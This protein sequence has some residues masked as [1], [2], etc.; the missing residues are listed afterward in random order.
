MYSPRPGVVNRSCLYACRLVSVLSKPIDA[1]LFPQ[2][3][4]DSSIAKI[5]WP[6]DAIDFCKTNIKINLQ[7]FSYKLKF[8]SH[9]G[10]YLM[11]KTKISCNKQTF[12]QEQMSHSIMECKVTTE[13]MI[14][15]PKVIIGPMLQGY[16][17][18]TLFQ[19]QLKHAFV[20]YSWPNVIWV[21]HRK[22]WPD[23][24]TPSWVLEVDQRT[25]IIWA[26]SCNVCSSRKQII[27]SISYKITWNTEKVVRS[28]KR[29]RGY[30]A[31]CFGSYKTSVV[32]PEKSNFDPKKK[33]LLSW[34]MH[35]SVISSCIKRQL[36]R[37][38]MIDQRKIFVHP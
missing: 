29:I 6:G 11:R 30:S 1:S 37:S 31:L 14:Y 21:D 4:F 25:A 34:E 5:P 33:N 12:Y 19:S 9:P 32:A 13:K 15:H 16:P 18:K 7:A 2:V 38:T 3:A 36:T 17:I 10:R 22:L 23:W 28:L 24:S 26:A 27:T 20:K 8:N 35:Q